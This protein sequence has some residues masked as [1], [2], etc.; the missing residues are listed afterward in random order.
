ATDA[1]VP[2]PVHLCRRLERRS[3][4][5]R[6]QPA[7]VHRP[8]ELRGAGQRHAAGD[9]PPPAAARWYL[10]GRFPGRDRDGRRRVDPIRPT[11]LRPGLSRRQPPDRRR[12]DPRQRPPA[13]P[14]A[15]RCRLRHDR[16]GPGHGP[17]CG[18][19]DRDRGAGLGTALRPS[20]RDD[21]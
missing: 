18:I 17:G 4:R 19:G 3:G 20:R 12:G 9:E 16:R 10:R 2:G 7:P 6:P 1:T 21:L 15:E 13:V 5:I 14:V 11:G 8:G